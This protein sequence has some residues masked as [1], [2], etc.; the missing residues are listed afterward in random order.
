MAETGA[1][2]YKRWRS[3]FELARKARGYREWLETSKNIVRRYRDERGADG[4]GGTS[5]GMIARQ[6]IGAKFNI[7]WSNVQTLQPALFAKP[8]KPIVE[9]RYLDRDDVGRAASVILER[10]LAYEID[11]GNYVDSLKKAVLD[12]LLPGRGVVRLRYVP[13]F[14][15]L[16]ENPAPQ[17]S[18]GDVQERVGRSADRNGNRADGDSDIVNGNPVVERIVSESV[19]TDY[20][21]YRD[22]MNSPA[23]T[24]AEVWWISFQVYMTRDQLRERFGA[25]LGDKVNSIPLDWSPEE[26]RDGTP[27]GVVDANTDVQKRAKVQETWNKRTRKVTWWC[28]GWGDDILDERDDPLR[29][30]GFWP[31]AQPL[32]ATLTNDTLIP[33]PD[34]SE[35]ED[36]ALE[37]DDLTQRI[38][39]LTAAIK[40]TGIYDASIPELGRMFEE[41]FETRLVPCRTMSEFLQKAGRNDGLGA[42]W[43][44]PVQDMAQTLIH[45]QDA[46]ERVKQSLYEITGI[47][48]I[49]RG[50]AGQGGAKTATEQRIKGEFASL[51][52]NYMQSDVATFARDTLRVMGEII[53]EH[54]QPET[55]RL[56]SGYDQW[57]REQWPPESFHAQPPPSPMMGHNGGPP[58]NGM[59]GSEPAPPAIGAGFG[60]PGGAPSSPAAGLLPQGGAPIMMQP[61]PEQQSRAKADEMF[62]RAVALLRNDKLRGFRIDIETDSMIEP[63]RQAVQQSRVE[64]MGALSQ[65]MPQAIE[66]GQIN[67]KLIPLMARLTMFM[68]RGFQAG[69]DVESAFEQYISEQDQ[70]ARNP[71][72]KQPSPEEIKAQAEVQKQQMEGQRQQAQIQGDAI[73]MQMEIQMRE[74]EAALKDREMEMELQFKERE[75]QLKERELMLKLSVAQQNAEIKAQ[76]SMRDAALDEQ[77]AV[78]DVEASER[79][80]ELGMEVME[81]KAKQAKRPQA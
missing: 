10:A 18:D 69:R 63:D 15:R 14:E 78:R 7:L 54:Y 60:A 8:P 49:V 50:Q 32:F 45:L 53:A 39:K 73:K 40:V 46:R 4:G 36:Q 67:P 6:S 77:R 13:R 76:S 28:E 21:D 27:R 47:S 57:A 5:D 48:D 12:R 22:F 31:M 9:R 68:V 33:R 34:Y 25:R 81:A 52:L 37:L 24:W 65:F 11:D 59:N 79:E 55:L 72:P 61:S 51:R 29:L 42:V 2:I 70:I 58:M 23:R 43:L 19:E 71:P 26:T 74:Q 20:V 80:H 44:L 75:L 35:Y 66:A 3:E 62:E 38:T 64:F 41:G 30:E 56:I 17:G 16:P 1:D